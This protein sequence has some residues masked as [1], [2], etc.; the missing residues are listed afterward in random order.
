M[1]AETGFASLL[2]V[3]AVASFAAHASAQLAPDPATARVLFEEGTKLLDKGDW[4]GACPKF[5]ASLSMKPS[6]S[7]LLNIAKCHDHAGKLTAAA[8]DLRRALVL[9]EDTAAQARK[10]ELADYATE[11]LRAL[12]ERIPKLRIVATDPPPSL[13]ITRDGAPL[14]ATALGVSLPMD[15]GDHV[16]IASAPGRRTDT[17]HVV[18]AEKATLDVTIQLAEEAAVVAPAPASP[19]TPTPP[20]PPRSG[21]PAWAW[22][23][24]AV[25]L[26]LGGVAIYFAVDGAG[27]NCGGPCTTPQFNQADVDSLNARR[28]RD[29]AGGLALGGLGAIGI[30]IGAW[31]IGSARRAP[32]SALLLQPLATQGRA[33]VAMGGRF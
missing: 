14:P 25:G 1:R 3:L 7:A 8:D 26:A 13:Q 18:L 23:T 28:H 24:G 20:P 31:G 32:A 17:M 15:P 27:A 30:A 2:S 4:D 5:D 16:I 12:E 21:A 11:A 6:V 19:L 10:R 9:N 22:A 29:L 33:G